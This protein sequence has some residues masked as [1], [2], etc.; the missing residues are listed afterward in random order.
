MESLVDTLKRST[1]GTNELYVVFFVIDDKARVHFKNRIAESQTGS[2][3][4]HCELYFP[5]TGETYTIDSTRTSGF[6]KNKDYTK[7]KWEFVELLVPETNYNLVYEYCKKHT[8]EEFSYA[9]M[10]SYVFP[11]GCC[12]S[13]KPETWICS[14]LITSALV[15]GGVLPSDMTP[16]GASPKDVRNAVRKRCKFYSKT[17]TDPKQYP[18]EMIWNTGVR[19]RGMEKD[20]RK[21]NAVRQTF[22]MFIEGIN[23]R[24]KQHN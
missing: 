20:E 15:E 21:L 2:P 1:K 13:P 11:V 22:D 14:R 12:V 5:I 17:I 23:P 4:T 19:G 6:L 9:T 3:Y 24:D 7:R 16:D 10:L 18:S 8:G